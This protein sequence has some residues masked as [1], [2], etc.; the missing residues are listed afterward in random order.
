MSLALARLGFYAATLIAA[1]C[2]GVACKDSDGKKPDSAAPVPVGAKDATPI[3]SN[4]TILPECLSFTLPTKFVIRNPELELSR[5]EKVVQRIKTHHAKE[6]AKEDYAA[7]ALDTELS[8]LVDSLDTK[9]F[10]L[11]EGLFETIDTESDV[12][13]IYAAR[14]WLSRL[15]QANIYYPDMNHLPEI[16]QAWKEQRLGVSL[17][18][19]LFTDSGQIPHLKRRGQTKT[20]LSVV[21]SSSYLR[22]VTPNNLE[23]FS[24]LQQR[25]GVEQKDVGH[26]E[27]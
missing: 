11:E 14:D 27:L 15:K 23:Q 17:V 26:V 20:A 25:C 22:V 21:Q 19:Y 13:N 10:L 7:L 24:I 16:M 9:S 12:M 6:L 8:K 4:S 1:A 3:L 5:L 2:T 18:K